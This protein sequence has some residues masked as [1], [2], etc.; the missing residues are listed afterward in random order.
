MKDGLKRM[1]KVSEALR[2]R[3]ARFRPVDLAHLP[4]PLEP[5]PPISKHLGGPTLWAKR[6]DCMGLG[7]GGN[8]VRKLSYV[9]REA[10]GGGAKSFRACCG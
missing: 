7:L 9:L 3:L 5:M 4:T 1:K 8:K 6:D 10:L 2:E